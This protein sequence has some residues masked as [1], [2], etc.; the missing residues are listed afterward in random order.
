MA[1]EA[2][3]DLIFDPN[4]AHNLA[5]D[6]AL[7]DLL[8]EMRGRLGEWMAE[9][10]DPLIEGPIPPG[11]TGV[12]SRPEDQSPGDLWQYTERKPGLA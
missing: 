2:L 4:E 11:E 12:V 7:E 6:P 10:R 3:Y 9:T 8:A 5:S 1:G